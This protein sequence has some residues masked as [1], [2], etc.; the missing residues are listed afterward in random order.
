MHGFAMMDYNNFDVALESIT[1][2]INLSGYNSEVFRTLVFIQAKLKK[3][4][5]AVE[6]IS[7]FPNSDLLKNLAVG[8]DL[9]LILMD[10]DFNEEGA[11]ELAA[12]YFESFCSEYIY[13]SFKSP[14]IRLCNPQLIQDDFS[15]DFSKMV[16]R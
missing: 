15:I 2:S 6:T 7:K 16:I 14:L 3:Y 1:K 5:L 4:F 8:I 13:N 10:I 9:E 11:T 12:I